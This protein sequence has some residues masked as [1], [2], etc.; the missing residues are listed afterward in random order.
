MSKEKKENKLNL[1]LIKRILSY[2]KP[3]K[4][5]FGFSVV[6]TLSLSALAI[7]RP[8]LVSEALNKNVGEQ[9]DLQ[10]LNTSCMIILAFIFLEAILQF[11][12]I[13]ITN[14]LGQSIVKDLRNQ[15]Y[16]H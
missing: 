8:L 1:K 3:Y 12:N 13:S 9:K 7:I 16:K 10:A 6:L 2:S 4:L 11:T 5:T 14:L 15:I